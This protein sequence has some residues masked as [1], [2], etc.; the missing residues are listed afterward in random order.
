MNAP[1]SVE[2]GVAVVD[3]F[4]STTPDL[5]VYPN[6]VKGKEL[7][8]AKFIE[9]VAEQLGEDDIDEGQTAE[10]AA[11]RYVNKSLHGSKF[12]IGDCSIELITFGV[13]LHS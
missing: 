2:R 12:T 11:E 9:L 10:Q 3:S 4:S 13:E 7:V 6:T 5:Y 1:L 8:V